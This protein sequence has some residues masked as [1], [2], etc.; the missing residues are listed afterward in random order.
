MLPGSALVRKDVRSI[1]LYLRSFHDDTGIMLRARA[2]NGRILLE[3]IV[4]ISFEEVVTDHMWG[5]GP[6]LAIGNPQTKNKP[7][8]LGA[9]RDY[10]T[11]SSWRE[12]VTELM[13]RASMIVAIA[14]G[15]QGLAWEIDTIVRLGLV[16]KFVLL[17]PPVDMQE[18][19]ARW[20][21]LASNATSAVLP[22]EIDLVRARAVIF[23][24]GNALSYRETNAT[25]GHMKQSWMRPR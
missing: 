6:V 10:M 14:G 7:A 3:K 19:E 11:D 25:I 9:A 16:S 5:Y 4:K 18:L 8:P 13:Q 1:V 15:T 22:S 20:Q 2:N 12:K 21:Y 17:L 23:P 24:N